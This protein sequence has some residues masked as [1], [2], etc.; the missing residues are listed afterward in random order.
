MLG[1]KFKTAAKCDRSERISAQPTFQAGDPFPRKRIWF[2][3]KGARKSWRKTSRALS[4]H[5]SPV[6]ALSQISP[7]SEKIGP[8]EHPFVAKVH[9]LMAAHSRSTKRASKHSDARTQNTGCDPRLKAT[10]NFHQKSAESR[11]SKKGLW[12]DILLRSGFG[13]GRGY[14]TAISKLRKWT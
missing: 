5:F 10:L 1:S 3:F 6:R 9:S 4:L 2:P 8:R 14:C 11:P 7:K 12:G 13:S